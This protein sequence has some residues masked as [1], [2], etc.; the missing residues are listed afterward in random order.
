[1]K[2]ANYI[3]EETLIFVKLGLYET[4]YIRDP[5]IYTFCLFEYSQEILDFYAHSKEAMGEDVYQALFT[6]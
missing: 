3:I 6:L 2:N 4:A 5:E 1:M